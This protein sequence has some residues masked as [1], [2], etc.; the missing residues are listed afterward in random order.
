MIGGI[1]KELV[2]LGSGVLRAVGGGVAEHHQEGRVPG[3][4]PPQPML[5]Q[6]P[7]SLVGNH[8]RE[9]ILSKEVIFLELFN[10]RV[11]NI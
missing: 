1:E 11:Y 10:I 9:I 8:M 5:P 4:G 7:K 2:V 6:E 3:A